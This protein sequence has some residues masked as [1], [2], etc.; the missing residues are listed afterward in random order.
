MRKTELLPCFLG[1]HRIEFTQ[2]M[3]A[4]TLL[5]VCLLSMPVFAVL[6]CGQQPSCKTCEC[7]KCPKLEQPTHI[8][9]SQLDAAS[10]ER[11]KS[12]LLA[13]IKEET[14]AEWKKEF[15]QSCPQPSTVQTVKADSQNPVEPDTPR[16][17]PAP[18]PPTQKIERDTGG[19]KILR[20]TF[21]TAIDHRLPVNERDAFSVSD[22]S[23]YC[24]VEISSS[25]DIERTITIK[26]M[27]STGLSQ[28]YTLPVS[29]SPAWRTWSKLNL[30]KSMT[31]TWLCEVFNED[32]ILLAS[33]PF[34]VVD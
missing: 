33:R 28:S 4:R 26:F 32:N 18:L 8:Q 11:L 7:P 19:M 20:H 15:L 16:A 2:I 13:E 34:I 21:A 1:M 31:G 22:G 27:H 17:V 12:E 9:L 10:R 29:Q 25:E 24:F 23:V 3:I 30:T 5:K 6:G 14:R